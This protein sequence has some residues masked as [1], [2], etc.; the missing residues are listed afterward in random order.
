MKSVTVVLLR[1]LALVVFLLAAAG[2]PALAQAA[3]IQLPNLEHLHSKATEVVDVSLDGALLKLAEKF[4]SGEHSSDE[5]KVKEMIQGLQGVYVKSF[6]FD[7]EGQYSKED[8]EAVRSQLRGP[9]WS[10]VVGVLSRQGGDNVE[11]YT[12]T[13]GGQ[14]SG[15]AI[16]AADPKEFTIVNIVGVVDLEKLVELGGRFGIP[17]LGKEKKSKKE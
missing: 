12:M 7:K 9:G 14:M 2:T 5:A 4:L 13:E 8:V 11:V 15:M 16:I 3:K 1:G 10:R 17:K 6:E